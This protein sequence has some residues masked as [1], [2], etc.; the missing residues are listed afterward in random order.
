M[1][2]QPPTEAAYLCPERC[3]DPIPRPKTRR[4]LHPQEDQSQEL[5]QDHHQEGDHIQEVNWIDL[6]GYII[7]ALIIF[8]VFFVILDIVF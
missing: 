5:S 7:A 8:I 3:H 2:P 1:S 6:S 4:R